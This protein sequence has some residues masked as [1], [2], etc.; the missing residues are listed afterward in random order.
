MP[1]IKQEKRPQFDAL[2]NTIILQMTQG[3]VTDE[4]KNFIAKKFKSLPIKEV[5]GCLNYLVTVLLKRLDFHKLPPKGQ[6]D[7]TVVAYAGELTLTILELLNKIYEPK[8]FNY[9]RAMG[10]L[11]CCSKEFERRYGRTFCN[12]FL[13]RLATV[14]YNR[15]V[16]PYEEKKIEENGD[17]Q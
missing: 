8:Y 12:T 9:N 13:E 15:T 7:E 1:Y 11:T 14:F 5:D 4:L 6:I 17:V 16:G 10:M 3:I 2:A